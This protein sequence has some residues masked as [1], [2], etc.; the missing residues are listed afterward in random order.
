MQILKLAGDTVYVNGNDLLAFE[1]GIE[2]DIGL[3]Q[4]AQHL[5]FHIRRY[6]PRIGA[7]AIKDP[8]RVVALE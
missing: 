8:A 3:R 5:A 2:W 6:N 4:L 7:V 1:D